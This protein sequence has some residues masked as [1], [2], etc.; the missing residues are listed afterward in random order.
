MIT[1]SATLVEGSGTAPKDVGLNSIILL[2]ASA[3]EGSSFAWAIISKPENATPSLDSPTQ[4]STRL[5]L[6]EYYGVYLVQLWIDTDLARPQTRT[7]SI[8]VPQPI[9]ILPTAPDPIFDTGGRARNFA[10][11]LPG[12]LAGYAADWAVEDD[13]GVL[14]QHAGTLRGRISPLNYTPTVGDSAFCLGDDIGGNVLTTDGDVFSISQE[15]N[16]TGIDTINIDIKF[17]E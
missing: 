1:I 8:V 13:A 6:L 2:D 4:N 15:M 14:V 5:R 16:F 9:S 3:N 12:V 17:R 11:S 10:F 7:I